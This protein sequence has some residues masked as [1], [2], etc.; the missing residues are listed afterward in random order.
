MEAFMDSVGKSNPK[1][2]FKQCL[3]YF[4]LILISSILH[5]DTSPSINAELTLETSDGSLYHL[6]GFNMEPWADS[7]VLYDSNGSLPEVPFTLIEKGIVI[8]T[9]VS[10]KVSL[11]K[12]NYAI[13]ARAGTSLGGGSLAWLNDHVKK[14]DKIS[15]YPALPF[16]PFKITFPFDLCDQEIYKDGQ[17]AVFTP[18]FG[19]KTPSSIYRQQAI[20]SNGRV[21]DLAGGGAEIPKDGLVLSGHGTG[22]APG[23]ASCIR[24]WCGIG[25]RVVVD[26]NARTITVFTD[27]ETWILR[28]KYN[29]KKAEKFINANSSQLTKVDLTLANDNLSEAKNELNEAEK[30]LSNS[31]LN[32]AWAHVKSSLVLSENAIR[33]GSLPISPKGLRSVATAQILDARELSIVKQAGFN[34][35]TVLF[36][37]DNPD[38]N[39]IDEYKDFVNRCHFLGLKVRLWTWL[40][41]HFPMSEEKK[42]KL[43]R[44]KKKTGEDVFLDISVPEVVKVVSESVYET[45]KKIK[46]DSIMYDYEMWFGG[47]GNNSVKLFCKMNNLDPNNFNPSNLSDDFARKWEL[48]HQQLVRD[49]LY[50]CSDAA[51]KASVKAD[52]VINLHDIGKTAASPGS[53]VWLAWLKSNKF[54]SISPMCYT[55]SPEWLSVRLP[56]FCKT[57][58]NVNPKIDINPWLIYWPETCGWQYPIP[59][60]LLLEETDTVIREKLHNLSFFMVNNIDAKHQPDFGRLFYATSKGPFRKVVIK[61]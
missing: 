51:H 36:N 41:E 46:P 28:A 37:K 34:N 4:A 35:V 40:P 7:I 45:C 14:G 43:P 15:F 22:V 47:Y 29:I 20:V 59:T 27:K 38:Q 48:W 25:N 10:E 31:N 23:G 61:K 57:I 52:F 39:T 53:N 21:V 17:L 44:D 6:D 19:V 11:T 55:Q 32:V 33:A 49:F 54:D 16:V 3:F 12:G 50:A 42:A 13:A 2:I 8:E 26:F 1:S 24:K 5:A 9:A 30:E 58:K 60:D 56:E 18:V